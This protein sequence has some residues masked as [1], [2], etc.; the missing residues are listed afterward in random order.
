MA[1][2]A[3]NI[4]IVAGEASGD[5]HA[6]R[7]VR[8]FGEVAPDENFRF[9]GAAGPEMRKAGVEPVVESDAIAIVGLPEIIRALPMFVGIF[10][11]LV[12]AADARRPA[13]VV[14]VDFPDFNLRLAR[15]LNRRGHRVIYYIS[16][17]IWAWRKH[18]IRILRR[19]V[20]LIIS[21]LPFEKDWYRENGVHHVEYVGNPLIRDVRAISSKT[22]FCQRHGLD[23]QRPI[24]AMLPGS[25]RAEI[26]RIAPILAE[27][28]T[29]MHGRDPNLQFVFAVQE[30]KRAMLDDLIDLP[31]R[32]Y[33]QVAEGETY[34]AL[35]AA[36]AAAV[37]SG[38]ATLEAALLGVPMVIVY[39]ASR[40]NYALLRPLINVDHFG[41]INLVAGRRIVRELIQNDFTPDATAD[42]LRRLLDPE[43]AR[44]IRQQIAAAAASLGQGGASARAANAILRFLRSGSG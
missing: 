22:E 13:A 11:R 21:I 39:R 36:N 2:E 8:A 34:N 38:T 14:L 5:H 4:M 26:C 7:L 32:N 30:G 43:T 27:T 18:R 33:L 31:D 37:T 1:Q 24:I 40:L 12:A 15:A 19:Y 41:L 3:T 35:A 17:Q 9:F 29:K 44:D 6:A 23:P 25:R 42:E 10:R 28:A 20:D 16:P